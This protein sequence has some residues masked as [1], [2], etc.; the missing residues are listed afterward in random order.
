M[1]PPVEF[2][3]GEESGHRIS[4]TENISYVGEEEATDSQGTGKPKESQVQETNSTPEKST[5]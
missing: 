5:L 1:P 4:E 2:E 3:D